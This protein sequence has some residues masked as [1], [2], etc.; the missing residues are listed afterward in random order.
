MHTAGTGGVRRFTPP[1]TGRSID[2]IVGLQLVA[3]CQ[4]M[5]Q[6]VGAVAF[7]RDVVE[8]STTIN[9]D[10]PSF[11][12]QSERQL[13]QWT[14]EE[15][16]QTYDKQLLNSL[17]GLNAPKRGS[18]SSALG[19]LQEGQQLASNE[20]ERRNS[21]LRPLSMPERRHTSADSPLTSRLPSSG[22]V[23]PGFTGFW[24]EH[25]LAETSRAPP[26]RHSSITFEDSVSHR[27]SCDHSLFLNDDYGAEEGQMSNLNIHDRSPGSPRSGSKRRA[28]SPPRERE[29]RSSMSSASGTSELYHRRSIQ[30]LP[31][32]TSPVSRFHPNHSSISSASSYGPR[33]GSLGSSL[34][35][36]SVP[37]SATSFASGRISPGAMSPA[38]DPELKLNT[39]YALNRHGHPNSAAPAH[40]RAL[41]ESMPSVG[42]KASIESTSHSRQGSHSLPQGLYICECCPKKPKKFDTEQDLR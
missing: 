13:E 5:L 34:S 42:R 24:S 3:N 38:F 12:L 36:P 26:T 6:Q 29:D 4:A 21:S 27:G 28:S 18:L 14:L 22:A 30:Q 16:S 32:R 7:S 9:A 39:A 25:N 23:S 35:V 20:L 33:H 1:I 15:S 37:S 8:R 17:G 31:H 2:P 41:S 40:Q 11:R 10:L 19:T